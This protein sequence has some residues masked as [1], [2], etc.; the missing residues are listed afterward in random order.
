M[1]L[2]RFSDLFLIDARFARFVIQAFV[3]PSTFRFRHLSLSPIATDVLID[4]G[5][6]SV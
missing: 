5:D 1:R 2:R 4:G 6:M 3:I